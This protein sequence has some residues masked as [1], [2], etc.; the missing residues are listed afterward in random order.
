[1]NWRQEHAVGDNLSYLHHPHPYPSFCFSFEGRCEKRLPTMFQF[2]TVCKIRY[3]SFNWTCYPLTLIKQ[4]CPQLLTL[5][6][7][8]CLQIFAFSDGERERFSLSNVGIQAA[9]LMV[10][11]TV[12]LRVRY[13]RFMPSI[14]FTVPCTISNNFKHSDEDQAGRLNDKLFVPNRCAWS[15]QHN[16]LPTQQLQN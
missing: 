6:T 7:C 15:Y 9:I 5:N 11:V 13:R 1:M 12:K 3:V 8:N 10:T 14:C 4:K 16:A 2:V